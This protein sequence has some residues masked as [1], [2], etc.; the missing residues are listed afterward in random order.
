VK[1]A[2]TEEALR[3]RESEIRDIVVSHLEGLTM[4]DLSAPGVRERIKA[5]LL[6]SIAPMAGKSTIRVYLPQFVVQ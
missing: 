5:S 1:D 3:E 4:Q 6:Q 2:K